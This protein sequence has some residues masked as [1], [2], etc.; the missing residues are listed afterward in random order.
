MASLSALL[1]PAPAPN[2]TPLS[3]LEPQPDSP[4][5]PRFAPA[6]PNAP[7]HNKASSAFTT[8]ELNGRATGQA[9]GR[10]CPAWPTS[11]L[12]T[13]AAAASRNTTAD[14]PKCIKSADAV[15]VEQSQSKPSLES[16]EHA[17]TVLRV[18]P[19]TASLDQSFP[20]LE[21]YHQS[22]S[23]VVRARRLLSTPTTENL[24]LP[25]LTLSNSENSSRYTMQIDQPIPMA[26]TSM[27][28]TQ[29]AMLQTVNLAPHKASEEDT[30]NSKHL[31]SSEIPQIHSPTHHSPSETSKPI[32]IKAEISE[33]PLPPETTSLSA[34]KPA[35]VEAQQR[36]ND[37]H[38]EP[39]SDQAVSPTI[40]VNPGPNPTATNTSSSAMPAKRKAPPKKR[41]AAKKGTASI[42]KPPAK[43]RKLDTETLASSPPASLPRG[44]P[45]SSRASKT[46]APRNQKQHSQTPTRS[47]SVL[48]PDGAYGEE[49]VDE[50]DEIFCICRKPD[51]HTWMIACDGPCND[52]YHGR[53][54]NMDERDGS[55]I[56]KYICEYRM[57]RIRIILSLTSPIERSELQGIRY[58]RNALQT[59]VPARRLPCPSAS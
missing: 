49:D 3:L 40:E 17:M 56:D 41:P 52:W 29:D 39:I 8:D 26:G 38:D 5:T 45:A 23:Q 25:P 12:D 43:K 24:I 50:S 55:L 6:T 33:V 54:V 57:R 4:E 19:A 10:G 7:H 48:D 2:A 47:S 22:A 34:K 27:A 18:P 58:P 42:V 53:C 20:G 9:T 31:E 37:A 28:D 13:W 15:D 16:P 1:N 32:E 46:P 44:T 11:P 36:P 59:H 30:D 35:I 51:D 14:S 21:K